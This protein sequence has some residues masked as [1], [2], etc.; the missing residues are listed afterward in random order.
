M[1]EDAL[2]TQSVGG[3]D[4]ESDGYVEDIRVTDV[5]RDAFTRT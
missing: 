2:R 5:E 3:F 1:E 4:V